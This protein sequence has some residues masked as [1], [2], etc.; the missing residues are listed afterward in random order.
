MTIGQPVLAGTAYGE[1]VGAAGDGAEIEIRAQP[2][3]ELTKL[4]MRGGTMRI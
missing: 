2:R 4:R 3:D 1:G